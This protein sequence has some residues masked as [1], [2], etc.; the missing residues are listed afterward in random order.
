ML[1]WWDDSNFSPTLRTS[2]CPNLPRRPTPKKG[3]QPQVKDGRTAKSTTGRE[4]QHRKGK[5]EN[6]NTLII[7]KCVGLNI[8]SGT[9]VFKSDTKLVPWV[10]KCAMCACGQKHACS[11]FFFFTDLD[12]HATLLRNGAGKEEFAADLVLKKV[13]CFWNCCRSSIGILQSSAQLSPLSAGQFC[14]SVVWFWFGACFLMRPALLPD[15]VWRLFVPLMK[16]PRSKASFWWSEFSRHRH[17]AHGF[18]S[19]SSVYMF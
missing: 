4:A 17:V 15:G 3:G 16:H 2:D 11:S 7:A 18:G 6:K 12:L 1:A 14:W 8:F 10:V 5:P 13:V 9:F 19:L